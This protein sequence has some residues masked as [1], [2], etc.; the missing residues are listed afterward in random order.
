MQDT[1]RG[2]SQESRCEGPRTRKPEAV[3]N[4]IEANRKAGRIGKEK[5]RLTSEVM[6]VS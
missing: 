4:R 6:K 1:I 3:K 5:V 2:N